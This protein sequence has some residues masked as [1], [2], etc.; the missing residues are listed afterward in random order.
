MAGKR[1]VNPFSPQAAR[2]NGF[3]IPRKMLFIPRNLGPFPS[4]FRENSWMVLL[5]QGFDKIKSKC[6][7]SQFC[8]FEDYFG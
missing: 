1:N 2:P 8:G 3:I 4:F 6:A 5:G 7:I